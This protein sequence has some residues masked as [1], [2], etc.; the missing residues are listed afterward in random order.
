MTASALRLTIGPLLF[1][2][3][4]ERKR[5]FYARIAD[6]APVDT[7]YIGEVVC[8][9]RAP[10]SEP[11]YPEIVERL[12][13]GGKT[14]VFSS[15]AEVM[16]PRERAMAAALADM[17][18][19]VEANDAAAL[20]HL[21]GRP[22][23]VGPFFNTYNEA[24]LRF[25]AG[26]GAM[27]FAL[28]AELPREAVAVLAQAARAL[29][30]GVEVLGFGRA[31]LALSARCYHARAHGR[32]KDNCQFVCDRDADG[33]DLNTIEGAPWLCVNGVQTLSYAYHCLLSALPDLAAIGIGD[34]RLSPHAL[35]MAALA[36]RFRDVADGRL[37]PHEAERALIADNVVP[38]LANG[39]W[40]G[41]PGAS[42][43]G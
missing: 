13:R 19:Q 16:L 2:W 12:E 15:L 18:L 39:F 4:A 5:D 10:F 28:P 38:A 41:G 32:T 7:V 34:V 22:H 23:R 40:R 3:P 1:H 30:A 35:D 24:T 26:R 6:E 9:K 14:V 27:H 17:P 42:Y 20:Y 31:P 33:M 21:G 36:Q 25:L 8:S 29:G 11:L 43:L 37:D